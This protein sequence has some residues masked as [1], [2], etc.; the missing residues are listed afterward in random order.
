ML[1]TGGGIDRHLLGAVGLLGRRRQHLA[2]PVRGHRDEGGVGDHCEPLAPPAGEIRDDDVVA[3]MKLRLVED[4]P[5]SGAAATALERRTELLS[6]RRGCGGRRAAGAI[7]QA[8][9]AADDLGDHALRRVDHVLIGCTSLL[10][11][12]HHERTVPAASDIACCDSEDS[13]RETTKL[14]L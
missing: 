8:Q 6:H 11:W 13:T 4:E 1:D 7:R 10:D 2:D 5:A 9:L 3:E 14:R 12:V